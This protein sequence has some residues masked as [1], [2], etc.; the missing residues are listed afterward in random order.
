M[1]MTETYSHVKPGKEGSLIGKEGL[2]FNAH[3]SGS[4]QRPGLSLL[5]SPG[6][7]PPIQPACPLLLRLVLPKPYTSM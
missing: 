4:R 1:S 2:G 5:A 6:V 7:E 3:W